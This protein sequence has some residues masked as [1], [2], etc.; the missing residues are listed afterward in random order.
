V[1]EPRRVAC[2]SLASRVADLEETTLGDAVGYVVRDESV[3]RKE[4][5]IVFA[6]PGIVLRN[7]ALLLGADRIILDEFHE[8]S[9]DV[10]LLLALLVHRKKAGLVVMSATLDGERIA[11]HIGGAFLS[12]EGRTF[13]VDVR[14]LASGATL[15]DATDLPARVRG[16]VETALR[17]PGDVLVFLPGKAEIEAC[18]RALSGLPAE[19][20]AL[21]GGLSLDLQR[22][23]LVPGKGRKIILAT[24]VAETSLTIPGVG[25]VVDTGLVRQTRYHDGRGS[26]VLGPIAQ[27]SA[28]QR[29]GRAGRTKAG[30]CL[31]MWSAAARLEQITLPEVHRESLVPLVLSAA[32][33]GER[34]ED[35]PLFDPPKPYALAAARA[36]L[37]VWGAVDAAGKNLT[38]GGRGLFTLP[39]DPPLARLLLQAKQ[40]GALDDAVDLAAA[41]AVGRQIFVGPPPEDRHD[42]LRLAGCDATALIRAVRM[43]DPQRHAVSGYALEEARRIRKRLRRDL[44]LPGVDPAEAEVN[45]ELLLHAQIAADPRVIH[46]ARGRAHDPSFSNGGTEVGLSRESAVRNVRD[47]AAIVVFDVRAFGSG[48]DTRLLVT[49]AS[50]IPLSWIAR[51]GVGEDRLESVR[52]ES[53]KIVATVERVLANRAVQTREESPQGAVARAAICE[54]FT[55]GSLFRAA[56]VLTRERLALRA[57]AA[58]LAVRGHPA[59]LA[60]SEPVP[61]LQTWTAARVLALGVESG[62]D[63]AMLSAKDLTADDLPFEIRSMIEREFPRTVSVGDAVYEADYDL[64]ASKVVLRMVKG[65]RK[66]P[67]PLSY[68]PRFAGL[69]IVVDTPRGVTV[70][71]AR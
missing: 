52:L 40:N 56:L 30:V 22:R 21:H 20:C 45:R 25:V 70:L 42:D 4:T 1:V 35:L 11:R 47:V 61:D 14:Y 64:G 2:R 38:E 9:L 29:A 28:E 62:D 31:R 44:G 24:N 67:P 13:P 19:V 39:V 27:D 17:E 58:A 43:G 46:V 51:A 50:A 48:R 37:A 15:P 59:G 6:T 16:A 63:L 49:C 34:P 5:R 60:A 18:G 55:R 41:L 36:D 71:R 33:W 66:E 7:E 26:L 57:L 12:A 69:G 23:A 53:G 32:A 8:R 68:L 65:T 3:M 10:D 54:L